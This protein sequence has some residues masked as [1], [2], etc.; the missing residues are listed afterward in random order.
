M[1]RLAQLSLS[2]AAALA[3]QT[4]VS[5]HAFA[6]QDAAPAGA[7]AAAAAGSPALDAADPAPLVAPPAPGGLTAD[8][9]AERVVRTSPA[10]RADQ[11]ETNARQH[12]V[13]RARAA[14]LPR[15]T[16]SFS[17]ARQSRT[18]GAS[19]GNLVVAPAGTPPGPLP[20]GAELASVPLTFPVI[21]DRYEAQ[22]S[23]E[24][25]LSDYLL[26]LPQLH[27]AAKKSARSARLLQQANRLRVASEAR[28]AYYEWVRALLS[29]QVAE[30]ALAR[31]EVHL[32][33]ARTASELGTASRA[34]V[35]SVEAQVAG[36]ELSLA[37]AST[38]ASVYNERLRLLMH[39]GPDVTYQIG[40]DFTV[41]GAERASPRSESV[42]VRRALERRLE[43]QALSHDAESVRDQASAALAAGLPRLSGAATFSYAR[44]NARV[45]PPADEFQSSWEA[46]VR[47]SWSPTEVF[48]ASASRSA[49]DAR[50]RRLDA[51]REEAM[52]AIA[53]EVKAALA[54]L[55]QSTVA[56]RTTERALSAAAE[57]YRVRRELFKNGRATSAELTD[58]ETEWS[59][60][61][62]DAV[63][64]RAD[65]RI[66]EVELAHAV[67][68]DISAAGEL[69]RGDS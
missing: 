63:S 25:P 34:D 9:V 53:L 28:V 59:R 51:E 24:L 64:A 15:L 65:R 56:L 47:L 36:A 13:A 66:A 21:V 40:E 32:G 49:T 2:L 10:L 38:A 23:L 33:D 30:R 42:Q 18:E 52:D 12:E 5:E 57:A 46:G 27:A 45:M 22:S 3:A 7:P 43:L 39:D 55:E 62:L 44:P 20:A 6:A 69:E 17:Y 19:L 50:A 14:F 68:D 26:R 16:Q 58:A 8:Q 41:V 35:L 60:A 11:E 54:A 29:R 4:L 1:D 37:R 31:A 67:G 61:Q 48:G